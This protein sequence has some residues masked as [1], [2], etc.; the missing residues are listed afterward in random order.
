M[1]A[2]KN[3]ETEICDTMERLGTFQRIQY[4][5]SFFAT[6]LV[7]ITHINYVFVAGE[8]NYRFGRKPIF[9]FCLVGSCIGHFKAFTSDY[10]IYVVIELIEAVITGGAYTTIYG[11]L[12]NIINVNVW[13]DGCLFEVMEI[14]GKKNRLL[15]GVI[16]A[17]GIYTGESVFA[18]MAMYVPYW[19]N[20]IK[21]IYTPP[22]FIISYV[23]FLKESPR[24]QIVSGKTECAKET[25]LLISKANKVNI[26]KD[27]LINMNGEELK[28]EFK[29]DNCQQ[30]E[31]FRDA[32]KSREIMKRL[33]IGS[34]A[35]FAACLVYYGLIIN[36]VSLPGNKYT[37][38]FLSSLMS[39]PGDLMALYLMNNVGRKLT[40]VYGYIICG[41]LCVAS[42]CFPDDYT[43]VNTAFF[44][45]SKM[46]VSGCFIGVVTYTIEL[47]PTSVRG[48]LIGIS[49]LV[50]SIGNILAPLTPI[51]KTFSPVLPS[52]TFGALAVIAGLLITMTPETKDSALMD[53]VEQV[54]REINLQNTKKKDIKGHINESFVS[55]DEV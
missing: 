21:V 13:M 15:A 31:T 37:N 25:L 10:Y 52:L 20:L 43:W 54:E 1:D 2:T 8:I 45:V 6:V 7:T 44:L 28:K 55:K 40:L 5:F 51:M 12:T 36:S 17:F 50:A 24:W 42:V 38:F 27:K 11:D 53:T 33:V 34:F 41:L 19:K 46:V 26:N 49:A 30:K 23:Y 4:V 35:R 3:D 47:Y 39:Y 22:I 18:V 32:M 48:T 9:I 14:G 16:Y 29:I